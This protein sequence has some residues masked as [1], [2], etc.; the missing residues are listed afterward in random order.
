MYQSPR[1]LL[2]LALVLLALPVSAVNFVGFN[3]GPFFTF[4]GT[5]GVPADGSD[6]PLRV[7]F[8]APVG[9]DTF[10]SIVN[11]EPSLLS[12]IGGGVT[13]LNGASFA[14]VDVFAFSTIGAATLTANFQNSDSLA[15]VQVTSAVPLPPTAMLFGIGLATLVLAKRSAVVPNRD[16]CSAGGE[17]ERAI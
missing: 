15:T 1:V 9:V 3:P 2:S 17:D 4:T 11:S 12:V 6:V 10:V 14:F 5:I 13:V 8:D 16:R 7:G